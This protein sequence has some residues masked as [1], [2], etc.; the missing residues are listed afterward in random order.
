MSCKSDHNAMV[1]D[2]CERVNRRVT[3]IGPNMILKKWA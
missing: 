2:H 3:N 1:Y